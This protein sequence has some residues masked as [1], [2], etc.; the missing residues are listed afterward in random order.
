MLR[1]MSQK[2]VNIYSST[3][4]DLFKIKFKISVSSFKLLKDFDIFLLIKHFRHMSK[5]FVFAFVLI[6][7]WIYLGILYVIIVVLAAGYCVPSSTHTEV[8]VHQNHII[9]ILIR[10]VVIYIC[11]LRC[12]FYDTFTML[13]HFLCRQ[14]VIPS[15]YYIYVIL[16]NK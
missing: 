5:S 2:Y 1:I 10:N 13:S 16:S 11:T 9:H 8:C 7:I 6:N 4:F 14:H 12:S 3:I 15:I